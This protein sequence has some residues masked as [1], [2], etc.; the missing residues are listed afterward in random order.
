[1]NRTIWSR[2]FFALALFQ[3]LYGGLTSFVDFAQAVVWLLLA[4]VAFIVAFLVKP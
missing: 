2:L 3:W 4:G 1:M